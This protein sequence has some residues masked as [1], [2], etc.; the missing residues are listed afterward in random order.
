[1]CTDPG[2]PAGY[3]G[4]A[5]APAAR[6]SMIR[7]FNCYDETPDP[8]NFFLVKERRPFLSQRDPIKR[9][10]PMFRYCFKKTFADTV[11]GQSLF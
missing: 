2:V 10:Y 7:L 11:D 3:P 4:L 6:D 8:K 1:M 9:Y 5:A